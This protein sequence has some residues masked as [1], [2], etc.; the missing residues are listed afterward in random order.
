MIFVDCYWFSFDLLNFLLVFVGDDNDTVVDPLDSDPFDP[1]VCQDLDDDTCDDCSQLGSPDASNDGA[2]CDGDGSCD[3]GDS[4]DDND[5][6]LDT[7]D[8]AVCDP[9]ECAD[10]DGDSCDD[11]SS[12]SFNPNSDGADN[13]TDGYKKDLFSGSSVEVQSFLADAVKK[14]QSL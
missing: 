6:V 5:N 3:A 14:P 9:N 4:D 11:C 2:D 10:T 8:T 1:F 12:G 7:V 13:D